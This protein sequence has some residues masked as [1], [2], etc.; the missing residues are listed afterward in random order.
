MDGCELARRLRRLPG[1][2]RLRLVALTGYGQEDVRA[3][4]RDAGFDLQLLKPFDP[5]ELRRLLAAVPVAGSP[6]GRSPAPAGA[7]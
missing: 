6:A 5:A 2:G 3:R 1:L 4:C 7:R